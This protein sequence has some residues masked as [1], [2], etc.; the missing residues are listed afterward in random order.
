MELQVRPRAKTLHQL[1]SVLLNMADCVELQLQFA[2][3]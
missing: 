1:A 2:E 3:R